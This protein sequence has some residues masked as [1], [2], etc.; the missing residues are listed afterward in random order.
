VKGQVSL[1][2]IIE[3][4]SLG[5]EL[6]PPANVALLGNWV[7]SFAGAASLNGDSAAHHEVQATNQI[8]PPPHV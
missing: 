2:D 8:F 3:G 1:S 6:G 4:A 7:A 5:Y